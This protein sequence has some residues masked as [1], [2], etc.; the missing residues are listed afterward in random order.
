MNYTKSETT[1][2][3]E[4]KYDAKSMEYYSSTLSKVWIIDIIPD[5]GLPHFPRHC[6]LEK[7][8]VR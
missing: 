3:A 7:R 5:F 4:W 1:K 8:S 6:K 2:S